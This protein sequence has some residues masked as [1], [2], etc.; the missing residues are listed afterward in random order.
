MKRLPRG[1]LDVLEGIGVF[2][3]VNTLMAFVWWSLIMMLPKPCVEAIRDA[4]VRVFG[5]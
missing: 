1:A 5:G 2:L 3:M 4:I